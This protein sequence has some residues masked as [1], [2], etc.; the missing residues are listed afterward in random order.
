MELLNVV[1]GIPKPVIIALVMFLVI[2]TV[3]M[4]VQYLKYKKLDGLRLEAYKKFLIAEHMYRRGA[5]QEKMA[6]VF[7][8]IRALMPGW[9]AFIVSEEVMKEIVQGW[10]KGIKDLLDD[11]KVNGTGKT[12]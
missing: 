6:W 5:G 3:V 7:K 8:Q 2:V 10:F 11:G 1:K 9:L 4:V 12:E